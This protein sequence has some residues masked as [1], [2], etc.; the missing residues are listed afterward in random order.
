MPNGNS[1]FNS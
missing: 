1:Q